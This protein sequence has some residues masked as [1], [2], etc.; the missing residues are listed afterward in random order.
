MMAGTHSGTTYTFREPVVAPDADRSYWLADAGYAQLT[1]G[2][3]LVGTVTTPIAIIGG[4][5]TGLWTAYRIKQANPDQDVVIMEADICGSG[6]S[7]R[8]GGQVHS[9]YESL[10]RLAAV[11]NSEEALRLANATALAIEEMAEMQESGI[12]DMDLRLDGWLWTASSKAQ[13]G[14]W[15]GVLATCE[16]YGVSPYRT[17]SAAE[18]AQRT[19]SA[20]SYQGVIEERAGT[21]HPGKL[22]F[23]LR[24]LLLELGVRIFE[25][26]PVRRVESGSPV[27]LH[28]PNGQVKADRVLIANNVWATA[29]PELHRYVYNVDSTVIVTEP[30]PELLDS[31]G[32]KDGVSI[33]DS[34]RQVLYYQRTSDDRVQFGLGTGRLVY[35][36]RLG[37]R[38]NRNSPEV[39]AAMRELIRVYPE[40]KDVNIEYDWVGAIDC[41][42][43]HVPLVGRLTEEQNIMYCV[44]W[45]GT[46][47]AQIPAV[48][49]ILASELLECEDEWN[50]TAFS[51]QTQKKALPPEPIRYI[52]GSIVRKAVV[53]MNAQEIRNL[54]P[55]TVT[56]ALVK[57]MPNLG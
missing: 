24:K 21:L 48:S 25:R 27:T 44:G 49:H 57:L 46:G 7:G 10:D 6:A 56:R 51:R 20:V 28:T 37:A 12:I 16:R 41:V 3:P 17:L 18:I 47:L 35:K 55:G 32:W 5:L 2:D 43:S 29:I 1:D 33:C 36:D 11:T 9:W 8:N 13:E 50:G 38:Q 15:S 19:G 52:G 40:L 22:C 14:A 26:T 54:K 42:A 4:G 30:I 31:L 23:G 45:N 39:E 34:Q 53:R